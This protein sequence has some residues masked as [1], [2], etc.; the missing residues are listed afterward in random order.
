MRFALSCCCCCFVVAAG[1][2]E[3][4]G[5]GEGEGEA[6]EGEGEEGE[7]EGEAGEG[8]G[9]G[10][11]ECVASID[12]VPVECDFGDVDVGAE[13]FCDLS[14][15]NHSEECALIVIDYHFSGDT[16]FPA[17][18]GLTGQALPVP[19]VVPAKQAAALRVVAHPPSAAASTGAL[20]LTTTLSET[21]TSVPLSVTGR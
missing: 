17:V 18:F 11:G 2:V 14:I 13:A 15:E 9:E 12:V 1:C 19:V 3:D 5:E 8:E 16:P 21:A 20:L 4:P 6:G 10:E 7:G